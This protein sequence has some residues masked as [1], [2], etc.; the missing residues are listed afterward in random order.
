MN[1]WTSVIHCPF[2][3]LRPYSAFLHAQNSSDTDSS[4]A[5]AGSPGLPQ[6]SFARELDGNKIRIKDRKIWAL[7]F[8]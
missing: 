7:R 2:V 4:A 6:W 8:K 5:C 1:H 3:V